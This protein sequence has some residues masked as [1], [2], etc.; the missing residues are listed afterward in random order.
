MATATKNGQARQKAE[1]DKMVGPIAFPIQL[2]RTWLSS[3]AG[4]LR[5]SSHAWQFNRTLQRQMRN[6][7]DV[8]GPLLQLQIGVASADFSIQPVDKDDEEAE[9]WCRSIDSILRRTPRLTDFMRSLLEAVWAGKSANQLVVGRRAYG[10]NGEQAF[11]IVDWLPVHYDSIV[12]RDDGAVGLKV[13]PRYLNRQGDERLEAATD[14]D[15]T[16]VV[17]WDSR[18]HMLE[19]DERELFV[20]H[21]FLAMGSDFD[22]PYEIAMPYEG[23]GMRD[24]VWYHWLMK[25]TLLQSWMGYCERLGQGVRVGYY[26]AGNQAA[27]AEMGTIL[28]NLYGDVQAVLPKQGDARLMEIEI[29]EP[30]TSTA[31]VFS[32]LAARLTDKIKEMILGQLGTT[33][34]VSTGL[35][36][37]VGDQ[38]ALT[39]YRHLR[40]IA[41]GL[42]E[43]MTNEVVRRLADWNGVDGSRI[44]MT[45]APSAP[46][47]K[48]TLEAAE[49][50]VAMG[51][52][53][54]E[55][56]L[57]EILG[58]PEPNENDT[59]LGGQMQA[60]L[61]NEVGP[62]PIVEDED[63]SGDV[64]QDREEPKPE[65]EE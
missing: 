43:T 63:G 48:D 50:F 6:D 13:G 32:G 57:R 60:D 47:K 39:L 28:Q 18:V 44:K 64:E 29:L 41:D 49:R 11:C 20:L 2:Q 55:S 1:P 21:K 7:P 51:G 52:T 8:M 4:L 26:P 15:R 9:E 36:S 10:P 19:G 23:R 37:S 35:G 12:F 25:Q 42:A 38:H 30:S 17:G 54:P 16:T 40:F 56:Y 58:F 31:E 59:V 5:Q 14:K 45:I 27:K 3:V 46:D 22:D 34:G 61:M 62:V 65:P 24:I 53:L 33:E